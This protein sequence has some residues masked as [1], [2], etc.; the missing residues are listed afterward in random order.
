MAKP[1]AKTT[2]AQAAK[3]ASQTLR[4]ENTG[5]KSKTAAGSALSQTNAPQKTT[6]PAAASAAAKV[7]QDGRTAKASKTAA[8]SA[9]AQKQAKG[10]GKKK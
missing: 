8:A 7:L 3:K 6:S 9:L 10:S 1:K 4:S 5:P 2:G